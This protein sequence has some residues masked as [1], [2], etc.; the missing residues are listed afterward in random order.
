MFRGLQKEAKF[1]LVFYESMQTWKTKGQG[2][3]QGRSLKTRLRTSSMGSEKATCGVR[4]LRSV[5]VLVLS[6]DH[7][8]KPVFLLKSVSIWPVILVPGYLL[9]LK[10]LL[11]L[12]TR[13]V[14]MEVI[15]SSVQATKGDMVIVKSWQQQTVP[16][17]KAFKTLWGRKGQHTSEGGQ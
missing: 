3:F 13:T 1:A 10:N 7:N 4:F 16:P 2:Y 9:L 8:L 11:F 6:K 15:P 12:L 14:V 5:V 17:L